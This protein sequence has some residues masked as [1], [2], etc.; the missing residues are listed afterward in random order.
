[1]IILAIP[2]LIVIVW[3]VYKWNKSSKFNLANLYKKNKNPRTLALVLFA[4]LIYGLIFTGFLLNYSTQGFIELT[5]ADQYQQYLDKPILY[6]TL[7]SVILCFL[8]LYLALK[9]QS[10]FKKVVIYALLLLSIASITI[11]FGVRYNEEAPIRFANNT[12]NK[13]TT[14][15][16]FFAKTIV[17][18]PGDFDDPTMQWSTN[19]TNNQLCNVLPNIISEWKLQF[20]SSSPIEP[21]SISQCDYHSTVNSLVLTADGSQGVLL[22]DVKANTTW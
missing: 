16:G 4:I 19:Y 6:A 7:V 13:L 11:G 8:C 12:L 1:M 22:V 2:F 20:N 9:R 14:P 21:G 18:L 5:T 15:K 3:L 17:T 10:K